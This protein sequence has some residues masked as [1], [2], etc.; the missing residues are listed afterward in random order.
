MVS[1]SR[2]RLLAFVLLPARIYYQEAWRALELQR[3]TTVEPPDS[4]AKSWD[5]FYLHSSTAHFTTTAFQKVNALERLQSLKNLPFRKIRSGAAAMIRQ[6]NNIIHIASAI[7][8][9]S[10]RALGFVSQHRVPSL[11]KGFVGLPT[12]VKPSLLFR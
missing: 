6:S 2:G 11:T 7:C 9:R 8:S 10:N 5:D 4:C 1:N 3:T 12:L